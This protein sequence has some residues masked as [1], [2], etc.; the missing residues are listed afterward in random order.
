MSLIT[1][2]IGLVIGFAILVFLIFPES[3]VLFKGL[4]GRFFENVASTPEGAASIY[5]E[6][7]KDATETY[8]NAL[9]AHRQAKGRLKSAHEELE[10]LQKELDSV[11][12]KCNSLARSG[13]KELL[14]VTAQK[15]QSIAK[16]IA[17]LQDAYDKYVALE[18]E[19]KQM[20][21]LA[22]SNLNALKEEKVNTVKRMQDNQNIKE[23]Y[24]Q[25]D[26][27]KST[28]ATDRLLDAI[29]D[30]DKELNEIALGAQAVHQDKLSTK[31]QIAEKHT[32]NLETMDYVNSLLDKYNKP[33]PKLK[34]SKGE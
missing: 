15:R 11:E 33:Q 6:K 2:G 9:N 3:R 8:N 32:A 18:A 4:G 25:V 13:D 10:E 30:K 27:V 17:D 26:K 12:A 1:L 22:D 19:T 20:Y 23:L 34:S 24:D 29:R 31:I 21:E 28:S 16:R 14:I 5:G 7:I